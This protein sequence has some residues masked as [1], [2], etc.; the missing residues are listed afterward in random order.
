M[1]DYELRQLVY[2]THADIKISRKNNVLTYEKVYETV[3]TPIL[4]YTWGWK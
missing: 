1:M 2:S 3:K 4:Y